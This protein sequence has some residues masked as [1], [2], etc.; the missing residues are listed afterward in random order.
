M[1]AW[2]NILETLKPKINA[3]SFE[4]WLKP[5]RM[6]PSSNGKMRLEV[7]NLQFEEIIREKWGK[8]ISKLAVKGGFQKV[9]YYPEIIEPAHQPPAEEPEP[10]EEAPSPRRKDSAKCPQ[11]PEEAWYGLSETYRKIIGPR[12][13]SS[14]N[15]HLA[16]FMTMVGAALGKSVYMNVS[17]VVYPNLFTVI[18]GESAWGRKGVAMAPVFDLVPEINPGI[19][20]FSDLASGEG[21]IRAVSESLE[22]AHEKSQAS[23]LVTLD[24]YNMMLIKAKQKGNTL[25]PSIK[26]TFDTPT[27]LEVPSSM[28]KVKIK[29]PPTFSMLAASE[30]DDLADMD[31]RDVKGGLGNRNIYVP[32]ESKD[33]NPRSTQPDLH[34]WLPLIEPL[35]SVLR[36]Y[37]SKESTRLHWSPEA[38]PIWEKFYRSTRSRGA[39]DPLIRKLAARHCVYVPKFA[40]IYAALDCE[41]THVAAKHINPAI[42]LCDFLLDSLYHVF[43]NADVKPWVREEQDIVDYVRRKNGVKLRPLRNRFHRMGSETFDRRMKYLIS[44]EIHPD[45]HLKKELRVG[46]SGRQSVW[47]VPND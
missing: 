31:P 46:E 7:P 32:G 19:I 29:N 40:M 23:V 24:E 20:P 16:C 47:V 14:D 13:E 26:K 36:F 9:E 1:D 42:A 8:D 2:Q 17:R 28:K 41:S 6:L 45:R 10:E 15:F 27:V 5:C 34:E 25:I 4:T 12:V 38:F 43:R 22:S 35:S 21:L 30:P 37:G 11:V 44:D 33:P 39:D 18:V 3:K